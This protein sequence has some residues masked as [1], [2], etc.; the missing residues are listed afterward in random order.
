MDE[1][2]EAE[3]GRVRHPIRSEH[4]S[5]DNS[6]YNVRKHACWGMHVGDHGLELASKM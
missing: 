2:G 4:M 1:E 3:H 6:Q 5:S